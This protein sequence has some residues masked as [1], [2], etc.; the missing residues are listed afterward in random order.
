MG[1]MT[2]SSTSLRSR[3]RD[4]TSQ[5]WYPHSENER[6]GKRE[7]GRERRDGGRGGRERREGGMK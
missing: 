7:G 6:E 1:A 3:A 2:L 5:T 4:V